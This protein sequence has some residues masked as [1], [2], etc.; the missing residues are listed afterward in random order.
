M[1]AVAIDPAFLDDDEEEYRWQDDAA[2][3]GEPVDA[4]F[5]NDNGV[6][7]EVAAL[8][9][10]CEVRGE[11]LDHAL[12][13]ETLGIWGGTAPEQRRRLR[14]VQAGGEVQYMAHLHRSGASIRSIADLV[15]LATKT[16]R[17]RLTEAGIDL[18]DTEDDDA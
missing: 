2:C 9:N 15:G 12:R 1:T 13:H 7:P 11:C 8:C 18:T 4:F 14:I 10:T 5:P 6:P 3:K 16:V 17:R